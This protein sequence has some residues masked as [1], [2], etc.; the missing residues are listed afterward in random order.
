MTN[1]ANF[2]CEQ[3]PDPLA[4]PDKLV[5]F[6]PR[7]NEYGLLVRDGE[8]GYASSHIAIAFCPWCGA[9]LPASLR[10]AFFD[11]MEQLGIDYPNEEPPPEYRDS[12]WWE[13]PT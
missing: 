1:Q 13:G 10:D 11:R 6:V 7:F 3:H 12:S 2:A 8:D 5:E 4:C 9:S